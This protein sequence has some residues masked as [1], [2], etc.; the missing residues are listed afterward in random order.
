MTVYGVIA[1]VIVRKVRAV[2]AE[3]RTLVAE[4]TRTEK[5][6]ISEAEAEAQQI[7]AEAKAE[8]TLLKNE[9]IDKLA[10]L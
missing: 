5:R 7:I 10:K 9:L 3:I 6:I 1:A 2:V 8:T 4:A